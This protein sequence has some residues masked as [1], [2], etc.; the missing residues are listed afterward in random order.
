MKESIKKEIFSQDPSIIIV[1]YRISLAKKSK[2]NN[3][4]FHGGENGYLNSIFFD[5]GQNE[6]HHIP[7]QA[8][9]FDSSSESFPR[10]RITFDNTD[11]FFSLK[12]RFFDDFVGYEL[13]R[14]KTFSKFL[15][16]I[17]FP[18]SVNPYGTPTEDTFPIEKYIINQKVQ[19]NANIVSF[20]LTSPLEKE[21][22]FLPSRKIVYNTCQWMYR[23]S[24]GCGY[25][26]A[27]CTDSKNN[28]FVGD[29]G[30][31][32]SIQQGNPVEF[33]ASATYNRGD[34]VR[35]NDYYDSSIP[36]TFYVCLKNGTKGQSPESNKRLW[37]EDAC[38]KSISGCRARFQNIEQSHGLPFGGFPGSWKK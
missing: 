20:E 35:I 12:T 4:Y 22:S 2:G 26:G 19:E 13:T 11:G 17:N 21:N 24:V 28:P 32:N 34:Y 27:P 30:M 16:D 8:E 7:L 5:D 37:I 25:S 14:I 18:N 10:P 9:G 6:Y 33:D 1:L 36:P 3:Y 31:F 23:H 38:S 15:H 29:N